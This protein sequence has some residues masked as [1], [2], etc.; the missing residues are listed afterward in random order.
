LLNPPS[1]FNESFI[2]SG[3]QEGGATVLQEGHDIVTRETCIPTFLKVNILGNAAV[4]H[5]ALFCGWGHA[6][7]SLPII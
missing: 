3:K 7:L 4:L 5:F 6:K 1:S 2:Y